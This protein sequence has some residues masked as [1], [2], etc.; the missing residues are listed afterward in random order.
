M[1]F[2]FNQLPKLETG[3]PGQNVKTPGFNFE[4]LPQV[5]AAQPTVEQKEP[6][7]VQ[8]TIQS[9]AKP[10]LKTIVSPIAAVKGAIEL[11]QGK[12][13]KAQET[14][15]KEYDFGYFGKTKALGADISP[16]A[17]FGETL[18]KGGKEVLGTALELASNV[19]GGGG[20]AA[21]GKSLLKSQ[22]KRAIVGGVKT[23][24][25]IGA[26]GAGGR[27]LQEDK[28]IGET[29]AETAIGAGTGAALGAGLGVA[30]VGVKALMTP[31]STVTQK[32]SP[33]LSSIAGKIETTVLK[34]TK[35]DFQSGF[36]SENV[37]KHDLGG[38]VKD[39]IEKATE[40]L[41]AL[42]KEAN[43]LRS[44][45]Q[46]VIDLGTIVK[47][48]ADDVLKNRV[49]S[50]GVNKKMETA[51]NDFVKEM[52]YISPN[53]KLTVPQAQEVK[54]ALG[55]FGSW[56]YG[57]KDLDATAQ[58][59]VANIMYSKIKTAIEKNSPKELATVNKAMSEIIPIKNAAIRRLPIEERNN[60][61]GLGDIISA[62]VAL[63]NPTGWGLLIA[64][65]LQKS[66][67]FAQ[68]LYKGSEKL[69][70]GAE[71]LQKKAPNIKSTP[72]N[73][74]NR[75]KVLRPAGNKIIQA[76]KTTP[77]AEI[78]TAKIS[79]PE[80]I[81]ERTQPLRTDKFAKIQENKILKKIE[82]TTPEEKLIIEAKKYKNA[83][84]FVKSKIN[85]Y[86]GTAAKFD[87]F[88]EKM[89]GSVTGA[90]SA[91]GATWFT[92][93]KDVAK[94]YSIY[95]AESGPINKLQRQAD[96]LEKIAQ[97]TGKESDWIKYDKI[98]E[99][100]EKL[101]TYEGNYKRR[102]LAN[103]KDAFLD[104]DF[105]Q[106]DAKG[107]TP[108]E[109]SADGDIDSW[110]NLQVEKAKKLKKDGLIIK[111]I[112]DAVGLYDKPSNH[113]AIFDTAKIKTKSQLEDIWNKANKKELRV[114][115][116]ETTTP[117]LRGSKNN[118]SISKTKK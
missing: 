19:A 97:K 73:L 67:K 60:A 66:G 103:I 15:T 62:G 40:K 26:L 92:D 53:G 46:Q 100:M 28:G 69:R 25:E 29:L 20:T 55:T 75:N 106:V 12:T 90:K 2:D 47:D 94:A 9:I 45:S 71:K 77:I 32:I 49:G 108:Q 51:M 86:H 39:T 1:A 78:K 87:T 113:F 22:L 11:S 104:G 112:D 99:E 59:R 5:G 4:N 98:V 61:I 34:P 64:N 14:A 41:K 35:K 115:K 114:T 50:F 18:R 31:L 65:K 79:L 44:G 17:G 93:N 56:L 80:T 42:R 111:N 57:A 43:A 109:L 101:D 95:A 68:Y 82:K 58:E 30:G 3:I 8:S 16:T 63:Q 37:L 117:K 91:H 118:P 83:D 36:K 96:E 23:G 13:A 85:A 88:D 70:V 84:D 52:E 24:A 81:K 107:K 54:E 6:G 116:K 110:L 10:F 48:T 7:F 27:A 21:V 76:T 89:K 33:A 102:E 105:Y 38:N 74:L 72:Q